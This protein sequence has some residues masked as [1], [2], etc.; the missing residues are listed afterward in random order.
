MN[1]RKDLKPARKMGNTGWKK[2]KRKSERREKE[3]KN[4]AD[5]MNE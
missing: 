1:P 5:H 3:K 2:D 4:G